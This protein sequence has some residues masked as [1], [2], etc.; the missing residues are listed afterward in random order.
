MDLSTAALK[1]D[2][3]TRVIDKGIV[4]GAVLSGTRAQRT[5]V[6]TF[7]ECF[8]EA[9]INYLVECLNVQIDSPNRNHANYTKAL[10]TSKDVLRFCGMIWKCCA[11]PVGTLCEY[12]HNKNR[13]GGLSINRWDKFIECLNY[14]PHTLF[15]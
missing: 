3:Y 4:C 7:Q 8:F 9:T 2:Q 5:S 11:H 15:P 14:N 12:L 6:N 1:K 10:F 13:Q